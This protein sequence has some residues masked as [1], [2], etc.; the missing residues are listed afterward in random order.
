MEDD[1]ELAKS[2]GSVMASPVSTDSVN[3]IISEKLRQLQDGE[4]NVLVI[5]S[6]T[7]KLGRPEIEEGFKNIRQEVKGT[8]VKYRKLSAIMLI[9]DETRDLAMLGKVLFL[10]DSASR[11]LPDSIITALGCILVERLVK[12]PYE[13]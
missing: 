3:D 6:N 8:A 7:V 12:G 10:N 11:Q 4:I 13:G 9:Q 1:Q 5:W 2:G